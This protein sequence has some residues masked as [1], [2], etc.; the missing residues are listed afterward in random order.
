[1]VGFKLTAVAVERVV[2]VKEKV[3]LLFFQL[4]ESALYCALT[5]PLTAVVGVR[6]TLQFECTV[7]PIR[8][9][10]HVLSEGEKV[11]AMPFVFRLNVICPAGKPFGA[12][13]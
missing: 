8:T 4:F 9:R 6:T 11:P 12:P 3:A 2:T 10:V 1:V 13:D 7:E 5:S